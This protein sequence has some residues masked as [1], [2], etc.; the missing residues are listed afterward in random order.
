MDYQREGYLRTPSNNIFRLVD[1]RHL[2]IFLTVL[3]ITLDHISHTISMGYSGH[4]SRLQKGG[5]LVYTRF[6]KVKWHYIKSTISICVLVLHLWVW[7]CRHTVFSDLWSL[8]L[9]K[10]KNCYHTYWA[11]FKLVHQK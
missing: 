7:Q 2:P 5:E 11:V 4:G 1:I 6:Y 10:N 3:L 8:L 9:R